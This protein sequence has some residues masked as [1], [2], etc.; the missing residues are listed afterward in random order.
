VNTN[1]KLKKSNYW[2]MVVEK[3]DVVPRRDPKKPNLDVAIT[4][5]D[6]SKRF[7]ALTKGKGP[8]GLAGEII[9][10]RNDLTSGPFYLRERANKRREQTIKRLKSAGYTVNRDTAVWTVY[11]IELDPKG[12]SKPGKGFIYVGMTSKSPEKRFEQHITGAR[13]K[14]GPLFS[15]V[16]FKYGRQLRMDLAPKRKYFDLA[17]AMAAEKRW[18]QKMK[19]RCYNA[20]GGR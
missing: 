6:P 19:D 2:V 3:N 16:V 10:L 8:K 15:R 13:N 1:K 11:V 9:K 17:S 5:Q 12:T 14:R 4:I 18:L 7:E 20:V